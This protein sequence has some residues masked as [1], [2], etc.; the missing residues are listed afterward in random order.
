MSYGNRWIL[1][2]RFREADSEGFPAQYFD[3]DFAMEANIAVCIGNI[4]EYMESGSDVGCMPY[5]TV[6]AV[7]AAK[8][9]S[10]WAVI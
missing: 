8:N 6:E 1:L 2:A 4:R 5:A 3:Y 7:S 10:M 9:L